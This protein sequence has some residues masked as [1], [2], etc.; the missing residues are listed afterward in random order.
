MDVSFVGYGY[1]RARVLCAVI[2][3]VLLMVSALV[4]SSS[5]TDRTQWTPGDAPPSQSATDETLPP[6]PSGK[7]YV[8]IDAVVINPYRSANV[9]AQAGGMIQSIFFEEGELVREG[10]V[11]VE[12]DSRRYRINMMRAEDRLKALEVAFRRQEEDAKLRAE[13]LELDATTRQELAKAKAEAEIAKFRVGEARQELELAKFDLSCCKVKAPFTGYVAVR[14]KQPDESVERL[15]KIFAL[16]DSSKVHAVANLPET[17]LNRFKVGT[18]ATFRYGSD[19]AFTGT[20]DRIGKLIDPKSRTKR[21]YV[22]VDNSA[23]QLEVGM[24]GFLELVK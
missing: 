22:L 18:T 20:V 7:P 16:V 23:G 19:K 6:V 14:Y 1:M 24:T 5:G 17:L 8:K 13:L 12:L 9:A 10:Q 3:V 11:V 4:C 2:F 15:E 21:V